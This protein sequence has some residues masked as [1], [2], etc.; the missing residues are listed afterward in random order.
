MHTRTV[1]LYIVI[2][3]VLFLTG[4]LYHLVI[5]QTGG[6]E[7]PHRKVKTALEAYFIDYDV[8]PLWEYRDYPRS[9]KVAT[10]KNVAL[11]T[12]ISYLPRMPIDIFS[13]DEIHWYSYY[14]IKPD[15]EGD[16]AGWIL[17]SA[18]PDMDYDVDAPNMYDI[19]T[20]ATRSLLKAMHY[21]PTNG[22]ISNGDLI[23]CSEWNL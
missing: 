16:G 8:Y 13:F 6:A 11:T 21:D 4:T 17:I 20:T 3:I 7:Y 5:A 10:F 22:S 19:A 9:Q 18:G 12:P 23:T 2:C 14:S 1:S 15:K